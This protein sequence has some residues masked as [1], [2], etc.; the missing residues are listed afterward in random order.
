M[1]EGKPPPSKSIAV[2][3]EASDE[4]DDD[5]DGCRIWILYFSFPHSLL[6]FVRRSTR[7]FGILTGILNINGVVCV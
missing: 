2:F 5:D 3:C 4:E 7:N 6:F 1:S